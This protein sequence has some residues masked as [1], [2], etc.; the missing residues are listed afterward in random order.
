MTLQELRPHAAPDQCHDCRHCARDVVR[1]IEVDVPNDSCS[2]GLRMK[3]YAAGDCSDFEPNG[4][5]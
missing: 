4:D 2:M 5:A 3:P 1:C